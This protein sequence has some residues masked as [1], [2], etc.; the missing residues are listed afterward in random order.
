[1]P[2]HG[3]IHHHGKKS[4][5]GEHHEILHSVSERLRAVPVAAAVEY[6]RF[7][8]VAERL[9]KQGHY[10]CNL[11]TGTI[12]AQ[13]HHPFRSRHHKRIEYF[14]GNLIEYAN[15]AKDKEWPAVGKEPSCKGPVEAVG[16]SLEFADKTE[17]DTE[18]AQQV[19]EEN[20]PDAIVHT[21]IKRLCCGETAEK[22][23]K[24]QENAEI[25]QDVRYYE[26]K[27]KAHELDRTSLLSQPAEH[28]GLEGVQGDNRCHAGDVFR[29]GGVA[30]SFGNGMQK[31]RHQH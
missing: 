16:D 31:G 10:H 12:N 1:M 6:Y 28:Y 17:G 24:H 29:V 11:Y 2:E 21:Y 30:E 20:Q 14:V 18:C 13:L 9:C 8:G 25:Q 7:V 3:H 15:Q 4:K 19:Y 23:G 5:H 22:P 26:S 27:L